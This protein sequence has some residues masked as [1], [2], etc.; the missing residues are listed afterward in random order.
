ML[1]D[2]MAILSG[3]MYGNPESA[4]TSAI[5]GSVSATGAYKRAAGVGL[6]T[7]DAGLNMFGALKDYGA[8]AKQIQA[9]INALREE[10]AYNVKNYQ[11]YIADQL[12]SNK[13]SF[14]S[15][16]LDINTGTARAVIEANRAAST[17]DMN[18]MIRQYD[19]DL[20]S[21]KEKRK[22]NETNLMFNMASTVI[23][24]VL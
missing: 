21:L 19:T 10:K 5:P 4:Y 7:V 3:G 13:F 12:A 9:N 22:A 20:K 8:N 15:S 18:M 16:G 24:S 6:K 17:E 1:G 23:G 2:D 14:Y 11:Q